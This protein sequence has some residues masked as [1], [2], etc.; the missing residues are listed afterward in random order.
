MTS[1]LEGTDRL[2]TRGTDIGAR[3]DGLDAAATAARGRLDDALVDDCR[4][5]R[6]PRRRPAAAVRD[7]HGGRDRRRDRLRQVLDVQRADRPGALRGRRTPPDHVVGDGLRVGP[8]RC[9]RAARVARDRAAAPD[10]P[11]LDARQ[12]PARRSRPSSTASS[13]STCPTT[14]PPRSPTTSRSTGWS[15]SPTCWCGSS[16]RRSTPT[17]RS[18]TATSSRRSSSRTSCSWCSTTSTPCPRSVA[19]RCS[20]TSAG[21]S[22]QDGLDRVPVLPISARDGHRHRRAARRDRPPGRREAV[23]PGPH[24]RRHPRGRRAGWPRPTATRRPACVEPRPGRRARRRVRRG[25]RRPVVVEAVERSL[26]VRGNRA[27]GWPVF[28]LALRH[29]V[30]PAQAP[31]ARPRRGRPSAQRPDPRRAA[32]RPPRCSAPGWTTRSAP[33]PTT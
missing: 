12:R 10:H 17:P 23:H 28:G 14:T 2:V 4:R 16:T 33:S 1:L 19:S 32:R 3:I 15:R 25:R 31:R 18:T 11:R 26:R 29:Q 21:C 27:T 24:R 6:R 30:R 8:R 7:P 9:R 5:R 22:T 20:T 13:C